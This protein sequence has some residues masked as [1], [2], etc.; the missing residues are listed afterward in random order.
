[1]IIIVIWVFL[2][3]M[4]VSLSILGSNVKIKD[5]TKVL[6]FIRKVINSNIVYQL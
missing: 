2:A 6:T 3:K 1:M 5:V 4:S